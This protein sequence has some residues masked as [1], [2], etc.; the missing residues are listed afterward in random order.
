MAKKV[1]ENKVELKK[2]FVK[3]EEEVLK[4]NVKTDVETFLPIGEPPIENIVKEILQDIVPV[5]VEDYLNV[6]I[7]NDVDTIQT[8]ERG[9]LDLVKELILNH[10][11]LEAITL[12]KSI[13]TAEYGKVQDII[14]RIGQ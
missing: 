14:Q 8:I 11:N 13:Q 1:V 9:K 3:K 4:S 12:L 6:N 2:P 7:S 10:Q 5:N